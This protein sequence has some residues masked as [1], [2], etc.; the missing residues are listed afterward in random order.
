[1]A[2]MAS[3]QWP[4]VLALCL[5][6]F[7]A[8]RFVQ[9][10]SQLPV[11]DSLQ[12]GG[13]VSSQEIGVEAQASRALRA[14]AQVV[15]A[16]TA[17][18]HVDPLDPASFEHYAIEQSGLLRLRPAM[19]PAA[20]GDPSY[21]VI[22]FQILSWYPRIIVFPGFIDKPRCDH[23][24]D[25]AKTYM[26]PSG[27]AYKPGEAGEANQQTRT[28]SG[29]FLSAEQDPDGVLGWLE[30]R[31]AAATHLPAGAGEAYNVLHYQNNQHYDSHYD[32]FNPK[33]FGPQPNQRIATVLVYL[34]DVEEGGETVFKQE[35][36]DGGNRLITDWRNCDDGSYKYKPR[37]GDAVLFWSVTPDGELDPRSLHGGCPVKSGNKWVATKWIRAKGNR[38]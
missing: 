33:D 30:E 19:P 3:L 5:V 16:P 32:S 37:L 6:T 2:K 4:V 15:T 10:G 8:G 36:R 14:A 17:Q 38:Y 29:T 27:L 11:P 9:Q 35:G 18:Y 21:H 24:I 23:I 20:S 25:L 28:S 7:M 26:Y 31:I 22:P 13:R 1:M 34:S 12:A